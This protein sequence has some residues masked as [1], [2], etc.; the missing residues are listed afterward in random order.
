MKIKKGYSIIKVDGQYVV[1]S[2]NGQLIKDTI[3][4]DEIS[5][6]LWNELKQREISKNE[7]LDLLLAQFE[8][9]TVLA[10][11]E[12]DRFVRVLKENGIIE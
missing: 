10:L 3:I 8:I 12:I 1:T 7:M 6:F 4:L 11:G 5:L 9:S 2:D